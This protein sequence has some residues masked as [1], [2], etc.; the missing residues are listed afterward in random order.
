[1]IFAGSPKG[2]LGDSSIFK[3]SEDPKIIENYIKDESS[4]II[5]KADAILYPTNEI[6]ILEILKESNTKK[7]NVTVS[8]A[9]TGITGSKVPMGGI[10]I[11]TEL[12]TQLQ[13]DRLLNGE[14]VEFSD[15][16]KKYTIVVGRNKQK[17]EFY[18]IVPPGIPIGAFK[19]IVEEKELYY[20]PDP[21]ET[22]AFLG[23]TVATNA[24]GART[25]YYGSTRKF[26]RRIRVMLPTG[27]LLNIKRGEVFAKDN[28]F[29]IMLDN[30][31]QLELE[32]PTYVM[33]DVKKNAAG[34][35]VKPEMDLIDLF[36]GSE[37]TLGIITEIEVTLIEKPKN[38]FSFFAHFSDEQNAIELAKKLKKSNLHLLSIE[39]FD[40][41]STE[42]IRKTHPSKIP[43]NSNG[44]IYFEL[45]SLD[46]QALQNILKLLK[47]CDYLFSNKG[48]SLNTILLS[49]DDAKEIRHALPEGINNFLKSK[50]LPKVAT[51]I[52]VPE[53]NLDKMIAT[54]HDVGNSTNIQYFIFGHIGDNHLHFNFLPKNNE[55][56]KLA[57]S[58]SIIFWKKA[59]EM[60]GTV[61]A[62]HGVGK[63]YYIENNEKKPLLEIM[64]GIKGLMEIAKLKHVLDPHHILNIGNIIPEEYLDNYLEKS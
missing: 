18:A 31:K 35:F 44:I 16:G 54:Y 64:Y 23:G 57:L 45:E 9:G 24:S 13:P 28:K 46:D 25:F 49:E 15:S 21:T 39:F 37:G 62:E 58:A 27:H 60:G 42:F 38:I 34:Y 8:G 2:K 10:V 6:Q 63:K 5:G 52:A 7:I 22:T 29:K 55:E 14:L 1:M 36:I 59:V 33:P 41:Y 48:F 17:N 11:S 3:K 20:P 50:N 61:T 32:L 51:D 26:V 47:N 53:E 4:I 56:V 12:L 30:A 19:K 40:K 43:E